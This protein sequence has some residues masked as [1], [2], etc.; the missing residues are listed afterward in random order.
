MSKYSELLGSYIRTGNYP[1]EADYIFDS[2]E[3]LIKFYSNPINRSIL[4]EGL[5]KVVKNDKGNQSLYWV[6]DNGKELEFKRLI[7][8]L[9]IANLT[10]SISDINNK[11]DV[12]ADL[13]KGIVPDEQ[14]PNYKVEWTDY[15]DKI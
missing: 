9:E 11:L 6:V 5:L 2:E 14:L 8:N 1:L 4:H 7:G 3:E 15:F 10:K 12:K 13:V